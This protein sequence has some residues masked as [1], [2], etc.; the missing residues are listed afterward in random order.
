MRLQQW[1]RNWLMRPR[2]RRASRPLPLRSKHMQL[3]L[4]ALEISVYFFAISRSAK[5][6]KGLVLQYL[7]PGCCIS[8]V[9]PWIVA[10]PQ[11]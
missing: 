9:L 4:E 3:L 5:D 11:L 2:T 7:D 1:L 6:L 8:R 10:D